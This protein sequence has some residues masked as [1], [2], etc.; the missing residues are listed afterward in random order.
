M[1]DPLERCVIT[2]GAM[3]CGTSSLHAHLS[4]HPEVFMSKLKELDFFIDRRRY[5]KGIEWY[6]RQ[7][8][9]PGVICGESS[10]NYTKHP[11]FAGVPERMAQHVPHARLIYILRD[12][13]K[14]ALSHYRHNL[15]YGREERP[16]AEALA[17]STRDAG[18]NG[19]LDAS[20]YAFQLE[21]FL[22]HFPLERILVLRLEDMA[23]D[24]RPVL[25]RVF[26]FIG[27]DPGF[28]DPGF[29]TVSHASSAKGQPNALGRAVQ[30][31]PGGRLL[32]HGL[33]QVFEKALPK[34]KVDD[35]TRGRLRAYFE[36]DLQ[37]LSALTGVDVSPWTG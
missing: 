34:P 29:D 14:R 25:R 3:K 21:R 7:L 5:V 24:P 17:P 16:V 26:A 36:P 4:L 2:I 27:V 37:R 13:I 23:G 33:P 8:R 18:G 1:T 22:P 11:V 9:G 32:R 31:L 6:R 30:R 20:R 10:P 35:E 28:D 12:P 19:Y 15:S